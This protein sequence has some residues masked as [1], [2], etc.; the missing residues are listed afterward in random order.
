MSF[1]TLTTGVWNHD[2]HGTLVFDQKLKDLRPG[3]ITFGGTAMVIYLQQVTTENFDW[4]GRI[5]IP[6]AIVEH[7]IPSIENRKRGTITF[8]LRSPPKFY[9]IQSTDDLHLY[10]GT[11]A[12]SSVDLVS[13]LSRLTLE[14][15]TKVNR[16]ERRCALISS[17]SKNSALCMVYKIAFSDI[18]TA[19]H[20]YNH[21]KD[22]SVPNDHCW[23]TTAFNSA[24]HTIEDDYAVF[25][26]KL[27]THD[28]S[29]SSE[30]N[31]AVRFQLMALVLEGTITPLKMV[32]LI[33][34]V[35][36]QAKLHGA[37]LVTLAVRQLSRSIPMPGPHTN[38]SHHKLGTLVN[39]LLE[40]IED[41]RQR[42]LI[43]QT[44]KGKQ[45]KHHHLALT[46][47]ATVTPVGEFVQWTG[48]TPIL[49]PGEKI[50][51]I[52]TCLNTS[53]LSLNMWI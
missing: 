40:S 28:S 32:E 35:Q 45:K 5:D 37:E 29:I 38:S 24:S 50:A 34:H 16:L 1:Q 31:F 47:K 30:F 17:Y 53:S 46:Y 44:F 33:P 15:K 7:V 27:S 52:F 3:Y 42:E 51:V 9:N 48:S 36:A 49:L 20:A 21:L 41:G 12:P 23:R 4:H 11:E 18:Q 43:D 8:T 25:E 14:P 13:V 10:A 39:L 2:E 6:Y 22:F 26:D 19:K